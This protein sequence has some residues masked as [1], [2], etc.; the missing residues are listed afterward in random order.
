M[1]GLQHPVGPESPQ[2]YWIR[3][4]ALLG[5]LVLIIVLLV[6]LLSTLLGNNTSETSGAPATPSDEASSVSVNPSW[7]DTAWGTPKPTPTPS[8]SSPDPSSSSAS[9]SPSSSTTASPS[10]S[11]TPATAACS[12]GGAAVGLS[13]GSSSVKIGSA[14]AFTVSLTNSTKTDCTW[15]FAKLPVGVTV[16]S[17]SDRIWSSDDCAAWKPRGKTTVPAGKS[18]SYKMTWPGQRS[19]ENSCKASTEQLGAGYYVANAEIQGGAT[20]KFV[21]QLHQ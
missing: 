10:A 21:M 7:T 16:T 20:K 15:D 3:R 12:A 8:A 5:V 11:T 6:W 19:T 17:G 18:Y 2:T 9:G 4:G 14:V 13:A 1:R